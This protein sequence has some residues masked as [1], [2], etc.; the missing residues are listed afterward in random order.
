MSLRLASSFWC[1]AVLAVGHLVLSAPRSL[2]ESVADT[3]SQEVRA[4]YERCQ[5]A[6]VKVEASDKDGQ[7]CGTGFFIDPNG[8]LITSFSVGG[9]SSDIVVTRGEMKFPARRLIADCR[10]GIAILK[11]ETAD[12]PT[13]FLP[14]AKSNDLSVAAPVVSVAYPLDMPLTP[15]FGMVSGFSLKYLDR[16]FA[17]THIRASVPVH[18]GEGGAPLLNMSGEVVGVVIS[19][20]DGSSCFAVPIAAAEKVHR[21]YVR[22]GAARPGRLGIL[23]A[24]GTNASQLSSVEVASFDEDAPASKAGIKKGDIIMRVG[25]IA[26]KTPDDMFDALFFLTAGESVP[27]TLW[28]DNQAFTVE[29]E[30]AERIPTPR[31]M[32][33]LRAF[34]PAGLEDITKR[35]P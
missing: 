9:E 33:G 25:E 35:L 18:R 34:K 17:T 10:S 20:V 21:D 1:C 7:L 31:E 2:A 32:S 29:V 16:Y 8:T 12:Q 4:V 11:I 22:Y 15:S 27:V 5:Q 14:M 26:I 19:S 30:P 3:L 24:T 13:P 6:V 23:I 28:R